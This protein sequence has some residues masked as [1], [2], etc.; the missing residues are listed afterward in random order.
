M[1]IAAACME[2][3]TNREENLATIHRLTGE[4]ASFGARFVVFPE[5][6]VQGYPVGLGIPDLDVYEQ[7]ITGAD[8]IPG[9]TTDRLTTIALEHDVELVV[10]LSERA[11]EPG[12]AGQLY[13]SS[14]WIGSDGV[15]GR[16]RKIHRGGVEKCLWRRGEEWLVGDTVA[17]RA[18]FLICYDLVFPEA[19]RCLAVD[20]A[21][22]LILSTAWGAGESGN[23]VFLQG[24]DL[25]TRTRALENQ[26]F[27][28]SA[29]QVGGPA[30][31]HGHSRIVSPTGEVLA[32]SEDVGLALAEVD[33]SGGV[34]RARAR[35]W[36]GQV[37]LNDREPH[38]Y[39]GH[40]AEPVRIDPEA[41]SR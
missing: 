9:P 2:V 33:I 39:E 7:Q 16:Y 6:A 36:F 26:V 1:T 27:L 38:L 4:A 17:G 18:G 41:A 37:F 10:G 32:E 25:L 14:V 34:S 11:Q 24:Y 13:N 40:I 30:R 5:C 8:P 35:S 22:L 20:G 15:K 28:V 3:S 31:F 21:E 12:S 23:E 29:N 19:A